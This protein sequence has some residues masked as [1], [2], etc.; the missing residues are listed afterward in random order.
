MQTHKNLNCAQLSIGLLSLAFAPS[1]F[2]YLD[3][4]TGSMLI[5]GLIAGI[6]MAG[7]TI[8]T[9]WYKIKNLF[10]A[11]TPEEQETLAQLQDTD[12]AAE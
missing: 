1:A 5:Q 8:K 10:G 4:G 9:Y 12:N 11:A 3:P 7:I 6:A 2:A